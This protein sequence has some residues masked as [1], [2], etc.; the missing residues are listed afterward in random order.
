MQKRVKSKRKQFTHALKWGLIGFIAIN[1]LS[2]AG[3]IAGILILAIFLV[4]SFNNLLDMLIGRS[5]NNSISSIK[6]TMPERNNE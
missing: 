3:V 5:I 6:F 1:L 2:Y 4:L